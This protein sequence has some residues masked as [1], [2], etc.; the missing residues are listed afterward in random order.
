MDQYAVVNLKGLRELGIKESR[1]TL[2]R[3]EKAGAFPRRGKPPGK[4]RNSHPY[5]RLHEVI[6]WL[7]GLWNP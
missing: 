3:W 6:A 1:T 2:T 7:K 5:W 4:H